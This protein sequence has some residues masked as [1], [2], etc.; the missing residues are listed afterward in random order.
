VKDAAH[1]VPTNTKWDEVLTDW[2]TIAGDAYQRRYKQLL[3]PTDVTETYYDVS[4]GQLLTLRHVPVNSIASI[5]TYDTEDPSTTGVALIPGTDYRIQDPTTGLIKMQKLVAFVPV[6][7]M[8]AMAL[9]QI[10]WAKVVF[11]YNTGWTTIPATLQR[12]AAELI[13]HWFD[14]YGSNQELKSSGIGDIK[15]EYFDFTHWP[16]TV[17]EMFALYDTSADNLVGII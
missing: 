16:E 15:N 3:D 7:L 10:N 6:G 13:A 1:I 2:I 9:E 14:Q 12:G 5:T 8:E 17:R 11:V 4:S